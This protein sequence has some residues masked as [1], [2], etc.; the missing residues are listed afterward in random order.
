MQVYWEAALDWASSVAPR[1]EA[2]E[3]PMGWERREREEKE[4]KSAHTEKRKRN[5]K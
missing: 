5:L 3:V 4:R 2:R 1:K